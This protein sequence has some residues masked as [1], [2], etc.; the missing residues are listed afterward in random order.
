MLIPYDRNTL[1][2]LNLDIMPPPDGRKSGTLKDFVGNPNKTPYTCFFQGH[3]GFGCWV[4]QGGV[5][6]LV[7]AR[8]ATTGKVSKITLGT[9]AEDPGVLD[10]DK[11]LETASAALKEIKAGKL[12]SQSRE[13]RREALSKTLVEVMNDYIEEYERR[14]KKE[15]GLPGS[16][17]TIG[18]INRAIASVKRF[19]MDKLTLEELDGTACLD[20]FKRMEATG[21]LTSAEQTIR[22]CSAAYVKAIEQD[23]LLASGNGTEAVLES[24]GNP[25]AV[26][27]PMLRSTKKL[28]EDAR[29]S[30]RI[31]PLVAKKGRALGMWLEAL[32][33]HFDKNPAG[34]TYF[35]L[36]ML[37]G[38][39]KSELLILQWADRVPNKDWKKSNLAHLEDDG[40]WI[41]ELNITKT[42]TPK[43]VFPG[44]FLSSLLSDRYQN[45]SEHASVFPP[46][47]PNKLRKPTTQSYADPRALMQSINN[48]L[49]TQVLGTPDESLYRIAE[50]VIDRKCKR[51]DGKAIY[52]DIRGLSVT[53]GLH[54]LR[55]TFVSILGT[56]SGIPPLVLAELTGH[57]EPGT[58]IR[59]NVSQPK[60]PGMTQRYFFT[61]DSEGR[62]YWQIAEDVL[63]ETTPVGS[64]LRGRVL[65]LAGHNEN[66]KSA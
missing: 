18:A 47:K 51:V 39:R 4:G 32:W 45:R 24:K 25:F 7:K 34:V 6:L 37:T 42:K 9:Y 13:K 11:A 60:L 56:R 50:R 48:K 19:E 2:N 31:N 15:Y 5:S 44:R 66:E 38:C 62:Y 21:H 27:L 33:S 29:H 58:A 41:L 61:D 53:I 28:K 3:K 59:F 49:T 26:V 54:D 35:A 16:P 64:T 17:N 22:W 10:L 30:A 65:E 57:A 55:R 63:L 43:L 36:T 46:V 14:H 8:S 20:F 12:S 52:T 40:T 1:K 23:R